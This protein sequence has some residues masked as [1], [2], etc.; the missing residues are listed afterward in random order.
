MHPTYSR[1]KERKK[2]KAEKNDIYLLLLSF[3]L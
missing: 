1:K 3:E 2:L